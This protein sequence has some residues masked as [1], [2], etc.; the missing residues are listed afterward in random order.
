FI[1][2]HLFPLYLYSFLVLMLASWEVAYLHTQFVIF[3]HHLDPMYQSGPTFNS[4]AYMYGFHHFLFRY[5]F[6]QSVL[7]VGIYTVGTFYNMGN[8]Q[9]YKRFLP[10]TEGTFLE[11]LSIVIKEFGT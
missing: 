6:F 5:S 11:D 3:V 10:G 2:I 1:Q 8:C 7:G 4:C 9:C